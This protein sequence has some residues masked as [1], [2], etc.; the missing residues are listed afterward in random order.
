MNA[1][2]RP[3]MFVIRFGE[4]AIDKEELTGALEIELDRYEPTRDGS[5]R[6]AQISM[7]NDAKAWPEVVEFLETVGPRIKSLIE[8][9]LIGSASIDFAIKFPSDAATISSRIP[10]TVAKHAGLNKIDI[11]TSIYPTSTEA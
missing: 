8:L 3:P 7:S 10:A 9:R 1:K 5:S 11:E 6:Y 4:V 2:T